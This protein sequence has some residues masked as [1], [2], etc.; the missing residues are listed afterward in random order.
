MSKELEKQYL[1]STESMTW[2]PWLSNEQP[3]DSSQY[4]A[5]DYNWEIATAD[6]TA[7]YLIFEK[8][9]N[10]LRRKVLMDDFRDDI[11]ASET[12]RGTVERGNDT[13]LE[14]GT[15]T[16]KYASLEQLFTYYWADA[17]AGTTYTLAA[18]DT[19]QSTAATSY[20][21]VKEIDIEYTGEY[22]IEFDLKRSGISTAY[23]RVY[24]NGVAF[25]TEQSSVS[26]TYSTKSEDLSFDNG[27]TC[28]LWIY[29]PWATVSLVE[30]FRVK[31][32]VSHKGRAFITG[33]VVTD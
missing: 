22:T 3:L 11:P 7:D 32:D 1:E 17:I 26:S 27:D 33:T 8:G 28:E 18:A 4:R 15:D 23:W 6:A 9:S 16:E 29:A 5:D 13:E 21:K 10:G 12:K 31:Y 14:T 24:K 2:K 19:E 30:N 20:T 25:G